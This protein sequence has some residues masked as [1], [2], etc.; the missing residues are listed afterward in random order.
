M[1]GRVSL[2]ALS[3]LSVRCHEASVLAPKI[4]TYHVR[5]EKCDQEQMSV[6][7]ERPDD[8]DQFSQDNVSRRYSPDWDDALRIVLLLFRSGL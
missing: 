7:P 5:Y 2:T 6:F 3:T 4:V 8:A 1:I